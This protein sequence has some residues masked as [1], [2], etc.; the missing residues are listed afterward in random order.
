MRKQVRYHK[1]HELPKCKT[2]VRKQ[3][4]AY[5]IHHSDSFHNPNNECKNLDLSIAIQSPTIT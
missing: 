3:E 5:M 2:T 4:K 1:A